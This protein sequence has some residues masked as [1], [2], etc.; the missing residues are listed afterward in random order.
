MRTRS[1][2]QLILTAALAL[3]LSTAAVTDATAQ[4]GR[5][6]GAAADPDQAV[7]FMA[8]RL[9]LN[10]EQQVAARAIMR[11]HFE[12]Q[13]AIRV[14]SRTRGVPLAGS[15]DMVELREQTHARLEAL[16]TDQQIERFAEIRESRALRREGQRPYG[17]RGARGTGVRGAS[18]DRPMA[19]LTSRLDLTE[20]QRAQ[21][22]P[23]M[24]QHVARQQELMTSVDRTPG[25]P[26]GAGAE[27]KQLRDET[28]ERVRAHLN[29][30]QAA[31]FSDMQQNP[32]FTRAGRMWNTPRRYR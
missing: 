10:Q 23:I 19:Y 1:G 17:R 4:R 20:E 12:R 6:G 29:D 32:G 16:M 25:V 24:A 13:R 3:L 7:E 9:E 22:R 11:E 14:E 18:V 30:E 15:A 26:L 2:I 31:I 8:A 28:H 21:I 5:A 27:M